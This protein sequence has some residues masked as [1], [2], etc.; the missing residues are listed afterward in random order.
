MNFK[1]NLSAGEFFDLIRPAVLVIASLVSTWVLASARKHG[2]RLYWALAWALGTLLFPPI[3][4][5]LYLIVRFRRRAASAHPIPF[6]FTTPIAY[7]VLVLS[8]ISFSMYRD[9]TSVDAHLARAS[10]AKISND[11]NGAIKEYR[12]ALKLEDNAHIHKLLA[13]ELAAEGELTEALSEFRL[14]EKGGEADDSIP[15]RIAYLLET[16]NNLGQAK[17]EYE[18]FVD[19]P[20]CT[21]QLPDDRCHSARERLRALSSY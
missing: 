13:I 6:R 15:L 10:Y 3:V 11:R 5:P 7:L 4:F 19:G 21:Q 2:F 1:L 9:R 16:M 17:L 12:E 8:V 20:M 18:R 14:A